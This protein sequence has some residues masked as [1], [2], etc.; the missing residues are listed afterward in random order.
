MYKVKYILFFLG[1]I[2]SLDFICGRLLQKEFHKITYSDF[3]VINNGIKSES[4]LL[5]LGSS[6]AL[7]HYDTELLSKSLNLSS[8][9]MGMGGNGVFLNYAMLKENIKINKPKIVLLDIAPS[10]VVDK[11]S[12]SKLNKLLPYYNKY[13]SFKEIIKLNPKFSKLELVSNLYIYNSTIYDILRSRFTHVK[14]NKFGFISLAGEIDLNNFNPFFLENEE[15]NNNQIIYLNK[16][17]DLCN[18]NNIKLMVFVSPTYTKFD[19]EN[20]IIR[21]LDHILK[22]NNIAFFDYSNY[23]KFYLKPQYFMDQIHLNKIGAKIFSQEISNKIKNLN[24]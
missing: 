10:I 22:S 6:R 7:N 11:E 14:E 2:I 8:Y 3:G 21:K 5:I 12:Y 18:N 19:V 13:S 15:M 17:I 4:E 20:R 9:N 1:I 24:Y 23:S 16:I